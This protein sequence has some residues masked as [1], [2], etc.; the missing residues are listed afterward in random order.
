MKLQLI[1]VK[2]EL[3]KIPIVKRGL[4]QPISHSHGLEEIGQPRNIGA[5][6]PLFVCVGFKPYL[7][8]TAL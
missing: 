5:G 3:V 1:G 2:Q 7:H 4:R 6:A 8:P